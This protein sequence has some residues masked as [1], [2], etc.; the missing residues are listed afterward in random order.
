MALPS[1]IVTAIN[2]AVSKIKAQIQH[3]IETHSGSTGSSSNFGHVKAGGAPQDIDTTGTSASGTD[4]GYYARADHKHKIATA[5]TTGKG[6]VQ[7]DSTPTAN[8]N[9]AITSGA[10]KTALT[11]L[12]SGASGTISGSISTHNSDSSAHSTEMNKKVDKAQGSTNANKNVVTDSSGNITTEAKLTIGTGAT[13]AAAG[14]HTHSNYLTTHQ[15]ISGKANTADLATVATSG[16]YNDLTNKPTIPSAVTVDSSLS[17]TSTNPVQNKVVNSALSGKAS[18]SHTHTKSEISDFPSSMTPS[19]H[20]HGNITND[21]KV[22]TTASLPLITTTG[23]AVTT[24][25][26]GS[27]AGTFCQGNDSRLSNARTPTSHAHGNITNAGAI[28]STANLPV[29]TTT[30]GKLTTGSFGT[31]ANTFCQ[32]N[33][34]RLS[35]ARTPTAHTHTKSQITDFPTLSTVATSGSYNDLT[36]KPTLSSLGGAVTIEKAT[37]NIDGNLTRYT[38]KQNGEAITNGVI[39]IPKDFLVKSGAVHTVGGSATGDKTASQLGTGYSTGDKYIDFVINTKGNDGTDEHI[40]INVKDLV[41]ST[42]T[43]SRNLTSGTKIGTITINGVSTDLYCET[44]TNTTYS[45]ATTSAAG[46][47]SSDDKIKL[48]GI[49]SGANNYSHPST[50][51]ASMI[52]GLAT[53]ATSGSYNDLSNKPTIPTNTNQLTNGA[54]FLTSVLLDDINW[55][56]N[57]ISAELYADWGDGHHLSFINDFITYSGDTNAIYYNDDATD[58]PDYELAVKGDIPTDYLT[59]S[60]IKDNLTSTDTNKPLSAKQG[61]ELKTLVDAKPSLGT[62]HST[63]AYGDHNHDGTYLKSYTPPT[64]STTQAGIIQIGTGALN[65]AAG[66]HTH[67]EYLTS[68]TSSNIVDGTI[69]NADISSSAN[70]DQTKIN[71]LTAALDAKMATSA[72]VQ[73]V[74]DGDTTHVPSSD[75]VYDAIDN[76]LDNII[77]QLR[78]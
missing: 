13:N 74:T 7:L 25:S 67:S 64:A 20:T 28:G 76:V 26:F 39:D 47:M 4:N 33:D 57:T 12:E 61:K 59:S 9:N 52:T 16:S 27:S 29:I 35:D 68:V 46:L 71:G 62:T 78:S 19:S 63:A 5:S 11:S 23:G 15:D 45:N 70:I 41:D 32:G 48:N 75:A 37:S 51:S 1:S 30:S 36:N 21:G 2:N 49:A 6:I 50:H 53:V 31:T 10:V 24:G 55:G 38:I 3:D 40:Y 54:G 58:N 43:I 44:N 14:N 65:A 8:S 18:I 73:T 69:V 22:G 17:T 42:V 66:N 56:S 60:D 77:L 72:L 34:S